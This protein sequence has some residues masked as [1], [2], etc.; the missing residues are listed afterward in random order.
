MD[1][2]RAEKEGG[3]IEMTDDVRA[4]VAGADCV[5]SDTWVSMGDLDHEA[6]IEAFE[7]FQV[8]EA[9]MDLAAPGAVFLHCLP[10]HRGEEVTDEVIDG[11]R[12]LVWDEAENRIHA[13]KG[14]LAWCFEA[15]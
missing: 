11:P 14:I 8:D 10:A 2:A 6:R 9:L 3:R 5:I 13:Q 1:L 7:P 12:S 15:F 4:A